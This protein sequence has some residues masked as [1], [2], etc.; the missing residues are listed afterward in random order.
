MGIIGWIILGGLA[1]WVASMFA[2]TD[3]SMGIFANIIVGIIGA[4]LGGF[5][6]GLFG[7]DGVNGFNLYSF[8]VAVVGAFILLMIVRAFRRPTV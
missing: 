4:I 6:F 5:I 7:G 8:V 2:K 1:G 3:E